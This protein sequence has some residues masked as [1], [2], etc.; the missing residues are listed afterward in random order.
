MDSNLPCVSKH[1]QVPT[2]ADVQQTCIYLMLW[3]GNRDC[4]QCMLNF[5]SLQFIACHVKFKREVM[6]VLE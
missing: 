5:V 3:P 4:K 1:I 2:E 6:A